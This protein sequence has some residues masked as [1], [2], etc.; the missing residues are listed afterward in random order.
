MVSTMSFKMSEKGLTFITEVDGDVPS[1]LFGD[2]MRIRQIIMNLLSNAC[3]YTREGQVKLIVNGERKD[4]FFLLKIS[5]ADT[6]IGIK[7]EDMNRLFDSFARVDEQAN[8]Q[9]E[10]TGLGLNISIKLLKMMGS[11]LEVQSDYGLGSVFSFVVE[12][13]IVNDTPIGD[14]GKSSTKQVD[15]VKPQSSFKAP[16]A[17]VLVVDDNSINLAVMK[18]LLKKTEMRVETALSGM[19]CLQMIKETK[20][21][22]IFF[23]FKSFI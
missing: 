13:K 16:D 14:I 7:E 1:V 12:Q 9:I 23:Y 15:E 10:G 6:G 17:R 19:D 3:K 22:F 8:R 11:R 2:E 5:V 4:N 21:D 18:G 20:Y